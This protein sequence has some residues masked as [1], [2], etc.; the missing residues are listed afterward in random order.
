MALTTGYG[1][2]TLEIWYKLPV[3]LILIE[4]YV[5]C[6]GFKAEIMADSLK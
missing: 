1:D 3:M 4:I 6:T 2:D 5:I